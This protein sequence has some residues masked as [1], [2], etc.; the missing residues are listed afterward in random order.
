METVIEEH[1]LIKADIDLG[2]LA[3]D[4]VVILKQ[5]Q[6]K[7]LQNLKML[8]KSI[9]QTTFIEQFEAGLDQDYG[10]AENSEKYLEPK[11]DQEIEKAVLIQ[12]TKKKILQP[13]KEG[14]GMEKD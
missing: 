4:N 9:S 10:D 14:G 6:Q 12:F 3:W 13:D 2:F 8:G 1:K 11:N 5:R 7:M